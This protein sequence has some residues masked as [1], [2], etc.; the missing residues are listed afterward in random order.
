MSLFKQE[1]FRSKKI[2]HSAKDELCTMTSPICNYNPETTVYC[3]SE[4]LEHGKGAG[5]K[6]DDRYGFYGCSMCHD[7]YDG[8]P[9]PHGMSADKKTRRIYFFKAFEKTQVILK[10]K[11]LLKE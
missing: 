2:R 11:G 5:L 7:W 1:K 8:K 4:E 3:H 9:V 10:N 6:S